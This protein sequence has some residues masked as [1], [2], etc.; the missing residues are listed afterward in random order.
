MLKREQP[1]AA[2][3][4]G[5]VIVGIWL[6][7]RQTSMRDRPRPEDCFRE[8]RNLTPISVERSAESTER[9]YITKLD[10]DHDGAKLAKQARNCLPERFEGLD[11][12]G[13]RFS[14]ANRHGETIYIAAVSDAKAQTPVPPV[15]VQGNQPP[16][17]GTHVAL[18][19]VTVLNTPP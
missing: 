18:V 19:R 4:V 11:A 15:Y 12:P 14:F 13:H 17:Y 2:L 16:K 5:V 6:F 8:L 9:R 1:I 3:V 10:F 7:T